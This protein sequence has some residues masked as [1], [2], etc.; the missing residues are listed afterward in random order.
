MFDLLRM[1]GPMT[2]KVV[3]MYIY[4]I[5]PVTNKVVCMYIQ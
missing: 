3:C 2:N 1:E 5:G 4:T